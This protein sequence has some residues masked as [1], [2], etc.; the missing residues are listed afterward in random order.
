[1]KIE[2]EV[3]T[4][5]YNED[6]KCIK[7]DLSYLKVFETDDVEVENFID[8]KGKVIEKYTGVVYKDK[9]YKIN[10]PYK[11]MRE[12]FKPIVVAGLLAKSS[13]YEKTNQK[14]IKV[15]K[16]STKVK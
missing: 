16:R 9:Y 10:R 15:V 14:P 5:I 13:S 11:E 2:Y 8:A 4:D 1:M 7:K 12:A 6:G 3:L